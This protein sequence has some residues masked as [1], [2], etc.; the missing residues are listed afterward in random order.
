MKPISMVR[1]VVF[2]ED[3]IK[4]IRVRE[5]MVE[6]VRIAPVSREKKRPQEPP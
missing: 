3:D 1:L 6:Q 5:E 4:H 2:L